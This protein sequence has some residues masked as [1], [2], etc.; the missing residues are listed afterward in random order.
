MAPCAERAG[1]TSRGRAAVGADL[2]F[3]Q[4]RGV[5]SAGRKHRFC[6]AG[7]CAARHPKYGAARAAAEA[8]TEGRG[9]RG[10]F[11]QSCAP[12]R[13]AAPTSGKLTRIIVT[14]LSDSARAE[15]L[16]RL[17]VREGAAW[18]LETLDAVSAAAQDIDSHL[19]TTIEQPVRGQF[20]LRISPE[21]T[22]GPVFS[23]TTS[24]GTGGGIGGGAGGGKGGASPQPRV[25]KVGNGVTLPKVVFKVD[26]V[27]PEEAGT[28]PVTAT[29]M[30]SCIV[31]TG[32]TAED[33]HVVKSAGTVFDANAIDA[34]MRWRFNPGTLNGVPVTVRA[35]IEVNFRRE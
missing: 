24:P 29:V 21:L 9:E 14:G 13:A 2:A 6:E 7:D 27:F 1:R 25:Y 26:P 17:P 34:V 31:G 20:E 30:L 23:S 16:S 10:Q 35:T 5:D 33:I 11:H 18:S 19:V 28:E 8:D 3:R 4:V 15:L 22:P 12:V 32:G